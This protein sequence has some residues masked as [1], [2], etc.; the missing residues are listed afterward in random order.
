M[1]S[2]KKQYIIDNAEELDIVMPMYNLLEHSQIYSMTSGSLWN[3]YK[4]KTDDV[5]H[6]AEDGKSF[7]N[8]T[9]RRSDRPAEPDPDQDG[10]QPPQPPQPPVPSLK[11]EVTL[12]LKYLSNFWRFLN[13][14]LINCE[15]EFDLSCTKDCVLSEH[16]NRITG[17]KFQTDNRKPKFQLLCCL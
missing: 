17:I 11:V 1:H 16:H 14:P 12:S 6:N 15:I 10:N 5:E 8:L 7:D 4:D 9:P 3:C 13:L 2:K